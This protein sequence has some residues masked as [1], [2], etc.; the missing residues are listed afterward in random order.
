MA[1]KKQSIVELARPVV[2]LGYAASKVS[3]LCMAIDANAEAGRPIPDIVISEFK[4]LQLV[5]QAGVD[6]AITFRGFMKAAINHAKAAQEEW[7]R[8]KKQ[9]ENALESFDENVVK[10]VLQG[11]RSR[12]FRGT[13]GG[14]ALHKNPPSLVTSWGDRVLSKEIIDMFGVD[15]EFIDIIPPSTETTYRLKTSEVKAAMKEGR[16]FPWAELSHGERVAET[17]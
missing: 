9:L 3:A 15:D 4:D 16:E 10:P 5:E 11:D 2:D 12:L 7:Y 8:R 17:K 13:I 14:L 1:G 6:Q